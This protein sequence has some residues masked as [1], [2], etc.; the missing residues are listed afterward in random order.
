MAVLNHRTNALHSE[1]CWQEKGGVRFRG[2]M[3]TAQPDGWHREGLL[4]SGE[5]PHQTEQNPLQSGKQVQV[6]VTTGVERTTG[7]SKVLTSSSLLNAPENLEG[8]TARAKE[9]N[10]A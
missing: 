8:I 6:C 7:T 4:S 3:D 1:Y 2:S 10:L 9:N 5:L